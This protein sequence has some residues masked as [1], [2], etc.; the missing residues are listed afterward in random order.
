MSD[1]RALSRIR[2]YLADAVYAPSF[3]QCGLCPGSGPLVTHP[4]VGNA[5]PA[6]KQGIL[7]PSALCN[8]VKENPFLAKEPLKFRPLTAPIIH[9]RSEFVKTFWANLCT[10]C[11]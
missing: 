6:E 2:A 1:P 10:I 4:P 9:A 7:K 8:I 5:P 3:F 11:E